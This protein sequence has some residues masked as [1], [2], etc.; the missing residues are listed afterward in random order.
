MEVTFW[1]V[2]GSIPCSGPDYRRV[3]GHTSCVS[4]SFDNTLVI[5]DAG[6]GMRDLGLW[7]KNEKPHI[8][9]ILSL[10]PFGTHQF[11]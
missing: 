10:V 4:A 3:G 8:K 7:L 6:T 5:F 2:R 11:T 9:T 1:G